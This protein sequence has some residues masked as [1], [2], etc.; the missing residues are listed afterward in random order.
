MRLTVYFDGRFWVG[1]LEDQEWGGPPLRHVFGAEP[2]D[3]E[4]LFFVRELAPPVPGNEES[5]PPPAVPRT[6]KNPKRML[7]EAASAVKRTGGS[8]KARETLS[9]MREESK[10]EARRRDKRKE[11][12]E[13]ER[14]RA[15]AKLKARKRHRGH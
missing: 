14:K 6:P 5:G 13:A 7:K 15:A 8:T 4:I 12:E 9:L 11:E 2:G 3:K 1:V 10:K